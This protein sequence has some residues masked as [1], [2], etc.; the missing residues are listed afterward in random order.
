MAGRRA[1]ASVDAESRSAFKRRSAF[2]IVTQT[3]RE[4]LQRMEGFLIAVFV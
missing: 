4:I 3:A 1:L 2:E